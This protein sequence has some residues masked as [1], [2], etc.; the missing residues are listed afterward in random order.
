MKISVII[1]HREEKI[2]MRKILMDLQLNLNF[3]RKKKNLK[4]C[5]RQKN[6]EKRRYSQPS[7]WVQLLWIQPT[8]N[9]KYSGKKNSRKVQK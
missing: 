2:H 4:V 6:E 1:R 7:L 3:I 5:T 8:I 9:E